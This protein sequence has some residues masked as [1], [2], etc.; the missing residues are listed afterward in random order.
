MLKYECD[1]QILSQGGD[2]ARGAKV[3]SPKDKKGSGRGRIK[4]S[5]NKLTLARYDFI[6]EAGY[7]PDTPQGRKLAKYLHAAEKEFPVKALTLYQNPE[8]LATLKAM[9]LQAQEAENAGLMQPK[10]R[11]RPKGS[12]SAITIK[13]AAFIQEE[14]LDPESQ[15]GKKIARRLCHA[16]KE[17]LKADIDPYSPEGLKKLHETFLYEK[18]RL[19]NLPGRPKGSK[20]HKTCQREEFIRY[21]GID[22][23]SQIGK[24]LAK[25]LAKLEKK[26]LA[27]GLDPYS[28]E[29][30]SRLKSI[31]AREVY[32]L[33]ESTARRGRPRGS[34]S[35]RT[36]ERE[37]FVLE[38]GFD[39]N[40]PEGKALLKNLRDL[41]AQVIAE[42]YEPYSQAGKIRFKE[43]LPK[44]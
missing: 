30:Q 20:S 35:K 31:L 34:K 28:V 10:P 1:S 17:L 14:G 36:I 37:D 26:L 29:G 9:V 40:A 43:L 38:F 27:E 39:P 18:E 6:R 32:D 23:N 8:S 42:G 41:E 5:K 13:R 24:Q 4:G 21:D 7:E 2:F 22:P 19:A 44:P 11:G 25:H 16:E 3:K 12:K 15:A 33:S